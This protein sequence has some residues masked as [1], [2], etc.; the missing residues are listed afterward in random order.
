MAFAIEPAFDAVKAL[1]QSVF[2]MQQVYEGVPTAFGP[3]VAAFIAMAPIDFRDIATSLT[4][5]E[6]TFYVLIGYK[7][8]DTPGPAERK[9]I[10]GIADLLPKFMEARE[11]DFG[12]TLESATINLSLAG[13]PEY[14]IF[15]AQ[16]YRRYPV[17]IKG[18]LQQSF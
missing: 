6:I 18:T 10:N 12:G 15:A 1:I 3:S 17:L 8:S 13:Q 5:I 11:T 4:E 7:V 14:E 2:G 9:L 16:E